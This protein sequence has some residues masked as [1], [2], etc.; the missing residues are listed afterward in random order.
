MNIEKIIKNIKE[1]DYSSIDVDEFLD[2]RDID[3]LMQSLE[4]YIEKNTFL[5]L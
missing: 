5:K 3:E 1:F 4:Y 2:D